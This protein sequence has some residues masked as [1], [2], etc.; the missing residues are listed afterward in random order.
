MPIID[1]HAHSKYSDGTSRPSEVVVEN[2]KRGVKLFSL[3]DHDTV[4]GVPSA[5]EKCAKYNIKFVTGVEVSASG[6]E[7]LHFLGYKVDIEDR[8]FKTFLK[9]NAERRIVRVKRI[10]KQLQAAGV[11]IT[12]EDVFKKV[13]EV[14]S[15][16]HVAD[17]LKQNGL[18]TSR[19][20]GFRKYMIPGA[21]GFV[22]SLAVSAEEAI[23]NIKAAGGLAVLAHGGLVK[24]H[25]DF[26]KWVDAGLDGIEVFYPSHHMQMRQELLAAAREYN[27]FVTAGSDNHGPSSGRTT[28]PGIEIPPDYYEKL[29]RVFDL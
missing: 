8:Q 12:E 1:L 24:E 6:H 26:K 28:K 3:T 29:L 7:H 9:E 16:A 5:A 17:A 27:L 4:D 14:V 25:W 15:R 23:K 18:T 19:Q 22:P 20:E 2:A 11:N 21:V 10:I 13:G